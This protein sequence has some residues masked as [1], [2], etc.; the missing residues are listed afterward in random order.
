M[1]APE[2]SGAGVIKLLT[3]GVESSFYDA[4]QAQVGRVASSSARCAVMPLVPELAGLGRRLAVVTTPACTLR[5]VIG[6][7]LCLTLYLSAL[8]N[9]RCHGGNHQSA[10]RTATCRWLKGWPSVAL[11]WAYTRLPVPLSLAIQGGL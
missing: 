6:V 9:R 8:I 4:S 3:L 10:H 11:R 2:A 5:P 1:P 7:G